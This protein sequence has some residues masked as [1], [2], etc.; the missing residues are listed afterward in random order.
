MGGVYVSLTEQKQ[1]D[2]TLTIKSM[3]IQ[4]GINLAVALVVLA[5][6]SWV[7]PRHSLVYAPKAKFSLAEK[8]PPVLG[9]GWFAWLKP[10]F[11][12]SDSFLLERI[13][14]D[15]V[16]YL[17]FLRLLRR[18]T[19]FMAFVG[20]CVLLP[21]NIVATKNTGDWPP[22][23]G[24]DFLSIS[25]INYL[26]GKL[27]TNPDTRW[28]WSP[29]AATWLFSLVIGWAMYRASCDYIEMR[30]T[31]FRNADT[32]HKSLLIGNVPEA[33]RSDEKLKKWLETFNLHHPIQQAMMGHHNAK[34]TKLTTEHEEAVHKLENTLASYLTDGK[35]VAKKRPTMRVGGIACLGTKVDA[36]DYYTKQVS[37]L[38]DQILK[39]RKSNTK[40]ANYGWISFKN[41]QWA[42]STDRALAK[43]S[44]S[45]PKPAFNVRL[46]PSPNDLIW[47]NLPMDASTRKTKRWIGRVFYVA[48]IFIWMI[49]V[50]ALSAT[51]NVINLIR[52][53]PNS[54]VFIDDH[55]VLMGIIQAWFTPIVTAI[56]FFVLPMIFRYISKIQGYRTQTTLDRKVLIKLY[57]F[58]IINNLL[59]FTLTSII[60]GLYGQ[61][62]SLVSSGALPTDESMTDYIV[63]LAKNITDVSTFWINYV[64]VKGLGMTMELAQLLPLFTI[65][66]S[67]LFTRPS[68]R[69]LRDIAK[70]PEFDYPQNYNLLL[71]FFTI[72]LIYSALAPLVLPFAF[73][74]FAIATMIYKYM[75]MYIYVTK[76]E[77]GGKMW[78]VL[79][80]TVMC[81]VLLFQ[82]IMILVLNLKGGHLQSYILIPLPFITVA[83]QYFYSR[84]IHVLGSFLIG[85]DDTL[86]YVEESTPMVQPEKHTKDSSKDDLSKQYQDPSLHN[87][88]TTPIVHE[89]VKHLLPQVY[90][91]VS[92]QK[93]TK[94][95][96]I[97]EVIE[98]T[99]QYGKKIRNEVDLDERHGFSSHHNKRKTVLAMDN[100]RKLEFG[101][102]DEEEIHQGV[103][104]EKDNDED[105]SNDITPLPFNETPMRHAPT[106]HSD[107]DDE[108]RGLVN[109]NYANTYWHQQREPPTAQED[110]IKYNNTVHQSRAGQPSL[111]LP[112]SLP[113][114]D[115]IKNS[116]PIGTDII[117][118]TPR[119]HT[120]RNVTSELIDIYSSWVPDEKTYYDDPLAPC[121]RESKV[122]MEE[123]DIRPVSLHEFGLP[124]PSVPPPVPDHGSVA[125]RRSRRSSA[126]MLSSSTFWTPPETEEPKTAKRRHSFQEDASE[127]TA[128]PHVSLFRQSSSPAR[129]V[130]RRGQLPSQRR[131]AGTNLR[132]A[133]LQRSQTLPYR[134]TAPVDEDM[135]G[136]DDI[137]S[138]ETR[139]QGGHIQNQDSS[140][141]LS[142]NDWGSRQ[143]FRRNR[144][145]EQ[146]ALQQETGQEYQTQFGNHR[147]GNEQSPPPP[148]PPH[149][150]TYS[151]SERNSLGPP[152]NLL[153]L[154][155]PQGMAS[156]TMSLELIRQQYMDS[157]S[158]DKDFF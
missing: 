95:H 4:L 59:V 15:A 55:Q 33:M 37:D 83:Y 29:A 51:S 8:R 147:P 43:V 155:H 46:S 84:R 97:P 53:L 152:Q 40:I 75:L 72:A 2:A 158:E 140:L 31:F 112:R 5:G 50:G 109:G 148:P 62:K 115:N 123:L 1:Q 80:Q 74:Y 91:N 52:L 56:F 45:M 104:E 64:C 42:H 63:Q 119:K 105:D 129:L 108:S 122:L 69:E 77:S 106:L 128:V 103:D 39:M 94:N 73:A 48:F 88:L 111:D 156:S 36:I 65:T 142:V 32:S 22:A 34:L 136:Q 125:S 61:I 30:Q 28:Y 110:L 102:L 71:F 86:N 58:F 100:G 57:F 11:S 153:N 78:P 118:T 126:P 68:P 79:F 35:A 10:V 99:Q 44:K 157:V 27:S 13:G 60:I 66:L 67:K 101:T 7:R 70:P 114:N 24:L 17:R 154:E 87:K 92:E 144:T 76:I 116:P 143:P 150:H 133:A 18:M 107:I 134:R 93:P 135:G 54:E 120:E 113:L 81:S 151:L 141:P 26:D 16:L 21:I 12:T 38:E 149:H 85:T 20:L 9:S 127:L 19:G 47:P 121:E 98:M 89:N 117:A 145:L 3:G 49:P 130:H 137:Q 139:T 82:L 96:R 132:V 6:F 25:G 138:I 41:I 14:C 90:H 124:P 146:A 131:Q 23:P